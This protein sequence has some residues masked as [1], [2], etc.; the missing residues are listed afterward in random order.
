MN[1]IKEIYDQT[2]EKLSKAYE[3]LEAQHLT[4]MLLEEYLDCSFEQIL[5]EKQIK[6]DSAS[7][8]L[9]ND[10]I[11]QL[12]DFIPIQYVMGKAHFFGREF[13]VNRNVLIPRQE[14]EELINEIIIDNKRSGLEILDIG[15]G[16]GCIAIILGLELKNPGLTALDIDIDAIEVARRNAKICNLQMDFVQSDILRMEKLP[17][18]YDI[19]VSNPPYV[20][21]SEKSKMHQNVLKFEPQI[22]LFVPNEDPLV[23]YRK[24]IELASKHL[25]GGGKLYF[26]INER[27]G[28]ELLTLLKK[29]GCTSSKL[30]RDLNGKDRIL[31]ARFN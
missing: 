24:I 12:L 5:T 27:F 16:S 2:L 23:F 4:R 25:N 3:E 13:L 14:T 29:N 30:I 26:E 31:K 21:V 8:K 17:K 19:I 15:T 11:E 6:Y 7:E 28:N 18:K 9:L 1:S 20:T 22:A 10:K